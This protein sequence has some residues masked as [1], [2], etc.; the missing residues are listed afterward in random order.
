MVAKVNF[1]S[2][3]LAAACISAFAGT[4]ARAEEATDTAKAES[5]DAIVVTARRRAEI[6]TEVPATVSVVDGTMLRDQGISNIREIVGLVPNAVIQDSANGL[7][8]FINIRGMQLVNT[9]AEPNVGVYRNGLYAGGH[10]QSLGAQ[11]DIEQVEV[12][13]GPQGGFYGRSSLGG[14]VDIIAT[15][16]KAELGGYIR[17]SYGSYRRSE[18][19]GAINL[20]ISDKVALRVTGWHFNQSRSEMKNDTLNEYIGAM[21]DKGVRGTLRAS[22]VPEFTV[23]ALAEYQEYDGPSLISFAPNGITGNGLT[24]MPSKKETFAQVFRDTGS[25]SAKSNAYFF[26]K[27]EYDA[28]FATFAVNGSYR[29]YRFNATYDL[30]QTDLGPP[31]NI[32][33]VASPTD[34]VE[35]TYLEALVTS[36]QDG[37]FTWMLGASY[38]NEHYGYDVNSDYTFN[39]DVVTRMPLGLGV[40]TVPV[41]GPKP[42]TT[43]YTDSK[44]VF[45]TAAYDLTEKLTLSGGLR[46]NSDRKRLTFLSGIKPIANPTLAYIANAAF[47][48]TFPTYNLNSEATFNFTSPTVTL[49]YMPSKQLNFYMTYGTGFRPGAFNLTPVSADTIPYREET[50]K[51]YEAGFRAQ[52]MNGKLSINGAVFYMP[53][54]NVLVTQSTP[55]AQSYYANVGT[56]KTKGLE[57]EMLARPTSWFTGGI[58]LGLLDAKFDKATVNAGRPNAFTLDGKMLPYTRRGSIQGMFAVDAPMS[59]S[60]DFVANGV[61]RFEWG[62]MLGDYVGVSKTYPAYNKIDLQAGLE[63]RDKTRLTVGVKNLLDEH[64]PQFYFYNGAQTVTSGRTFSVDLNHRF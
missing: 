11:V 27:T 15:M 8:T 46:Y 18:F 3:L 37:P 1:R 31:Y 24:F 64:V 41:G 32:K 47:S 42:G 61:F 43:I 23:E 40:Q 25:T 48:S 5:A 7:N 9:Q 56:S 34:K 33:G 14:T 57:L 10:R 45:A 59:E 6:L 28:G 38:F 19:E 55:L 53:Q 2:S 36:K 29:E 52:M 44:S 30:D 58:S 17:A 4:G 26:V 50:A 12:L 39:V 49:R 60:V 51:N 21:T 16:P 22:L 35:D 54:D 13:R 62:G 20:P 63:L